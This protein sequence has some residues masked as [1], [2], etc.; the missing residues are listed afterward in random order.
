MNKYLVAIIAGL[1]ILSLEGCFDPPEFPVEPEIKFKDIRFVEVD[2]QD[3]LILV[4]DFRDGDGDFG[5]YKDEDTPPFHRFNVILDST[6]RFVYNSEF[7]LYV[8]TNANI[9]VIEY[10]D[11]GNRSPYYLVTNYG[12]LVDTFSSTP[13]ALPEYNICDYLFVP[14]LEG[15]TTT[16]DK[17]DT[18]LIAQNPYLFNLHLKFFRKRRGQLEDI[19]D[20]LGASS[21]SPAFNGQVPVFD[22][23]NMGRPLNGTITYPMISSGF[24]PTFLVDSIIVEFYIY[25]RALH[26]S[27]VVRSPAFTL[28]GLLGID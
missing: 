5:I 17:E 7:D 11:K 21:C 3:S 25:D 12:T 2:G 19:T 9:P 13:I 1:V 16:Q 4:F 15:D 10:G 20:L 27:N 26:Q 6:A 23:D 8:L 14:D 22:D 18:V 28:P 24:K